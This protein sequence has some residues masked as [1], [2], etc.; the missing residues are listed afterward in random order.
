MSGGDRGLY[1]ILQ[2]RQGVFMREVLLKIEKKALSDLKVEIS[3]RYKLLWMKLFGSKVRGESDEESDIDIVVVIEDVNWAIEKD[4]YEICF[5]IGLKYD[6]LISPIIYS[7]REV[8]DTLTQATPF[9]KAVEK[10]GILI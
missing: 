7:M 9:F 3:K 10:E 4:I 2:K 5:Y 8:N 1:R 6:V